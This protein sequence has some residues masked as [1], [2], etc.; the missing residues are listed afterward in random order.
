[1]TT[2]VPSTDELRHAQKA[3]HDTA[4]TTNTGTQSR[5]PTD[6]IQELAN[7]VHFAMNQ[8][9]QAFLVLMFRLLQIVPTVSL[10][11]GFSRHGAQSN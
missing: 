9:Q 1:M 11:L 8:H 3:K 7:A 10:G 5:G 6:L 2:T 4:T